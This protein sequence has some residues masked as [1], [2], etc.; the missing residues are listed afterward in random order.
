M[1]GTGKDEPSGLAALPLR[2]HEI[3]RMYIEYFFKKKYFISELVILWRRQKD[4]ASRTK[5][6]GDF[7]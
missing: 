7:P 4:S 3:F 1:S 5:T 6:L 2:L